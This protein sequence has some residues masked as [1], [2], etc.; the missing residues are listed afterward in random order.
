MYI[1]I[2]DIHNEHIYL[3]T[4]K[5]SNRSFRQALINRCCFQATFHLVNLGGYHPRMDWKRNTI[6]FET[7]NHQ[8]NCWIVDG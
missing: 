3:S 6:V 5:T 2:Y 7:T 1:H 8:T 4:P